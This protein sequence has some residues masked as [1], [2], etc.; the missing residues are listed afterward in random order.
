MSIQPPLPPW[1]Q[2]KMLMVSCNPRSTSRI[3]SLAAYSQR[4]VISGRR[5][6]KLA[7]LCQFVLYSY[8]YTLRHCAPTSAICDVCPSMRHTVQQH[9]CA[10]RIQPLG[11]S[12]ITHTHIFK[13]TQTQHTS[14][15]SEADPD[16][17]SGRA[18]R[19]FGLAGSS[20]VGPV[21]SKATS[22]AQAQATWMANMSRCVR[23]WGGRMR[24]LDMCTYI[25]CNMLYM[26]GEAR[27]FL[28]VC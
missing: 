8:L 19:G 11:S 14:R 18:G 2:R 20:N 28:L 26:R 13:H 7:L 1:E 22:Q 12:Y 3:P 9:G 23:V 4:H 15:Q 25:C 17:W 27:I 6:H 21:S 16:P 24:C 10:S 5:S